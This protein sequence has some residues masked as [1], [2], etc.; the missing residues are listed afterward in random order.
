MPEAALLDNL[1]G[2]GWPLSN[3]VALSSREATPASEEG[4]DEAFAGSPV[5]PPGT[6]LALQAGA[7]KSLFLAVLCFAALPDARTLATLSWS[8]AGPIFV[9]D[10]VITF[11]VGLLWD[12]VLY[13][14]ASP[15]RS[16]A[17]ALKFNPRAPRD[18]QFLHDT[19]WSACSTLISSAFEIVLLHAWARGL[20]PLALAPA[21]LPVL[22]WAHA[23]TLA[24]VLSMPYVR[25]VHFFFLHRAMHTGV[26][27]PGLGFDVGAF[28]Y[29]HVHSLHHLSRNPTTWSGVSMHPVESSGYYS[30]M[31]VPALCGAHPL[32][33]IM[34]KFDLTIAALIGH[35][36]HG[37]PATG[38]HDH[39]LHH[40]H[41]NCNY[42]ESYVP[43]D[44]FFGSYAGSSADFENKFGPDAKAK[45]KT[46]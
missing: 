8:W 12:A 35:D 45:K 42:G 44:W 9:R 14:A 28:L 4:A 16:R 38:S 26:V 43:L 40:N 33:W 20:L 15:L 5:A 34:Y 17:A 11:V 6:H 21:A 7:L 3:L 2:A 36:G 22:W 32:V 29:K 31:L 23:P 41:V 1:L 37:A 24:W 30:A 25:I 18:A 10:M 13:S 39:W 27:I 46:A 19:F